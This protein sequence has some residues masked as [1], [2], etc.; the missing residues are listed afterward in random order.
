[1]ANCQV[2]L[3]WEATG[4]RGD[5]DGREG[6]R[7]RYNQMADYWTKR[8]EFQRHNDTHL[9]LPLLPLDPRPFSHLWPSL[10]SPMDVCCGRNVQTSLI[11]KSKLPKKQWKWQ[12]DFL[13]VLKQLGTAEARTWV[14]NTPLNILRKVSMFHYTLDRSQRIGEAL[15]VQFGALKIPLEWWCKQRLMWGPFAE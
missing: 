13:G 10:L 3:W 15:E 2:N 6:G 8:L 11:H 1:M 4:Q 5:R 7:P 12:F 14:T 9:S